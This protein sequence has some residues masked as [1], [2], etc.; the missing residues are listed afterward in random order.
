MLV[1]LKLEEQDTTYNLHLEKTFL[2]SRYFVNLSLD[3]GMAVG[4]LKQDVFLNRRTNVKL[5]QQIL[6]RTI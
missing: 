5:E 2:P 3:V 1:H 4:C 6:G